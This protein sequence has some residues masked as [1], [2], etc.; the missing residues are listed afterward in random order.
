MSGLAP[1]VVELEPQEA[2]AVRGDVA[3]ADLPAFFE[4]AFHEAAAA[5]A[6]SDVE[7]VGPPFGFYPEMPTENVAVEAGFPVSEPA[8]T[9]GS[10]HRLVLP[11]GRVV[12]AVHIGT[13]DTMESTYRE[14]Q[15][16]MAE[17][18]L[19]PAVGMWEC[20]LSDPQVEPD[21]ATWRTLIVW[22]IA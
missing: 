13:Y 2:I 17:R 16:W 10:A 7:I 21:P 4:R 5:A 3:V 18:G 8:A 11:G 15:S 20:Y 9:H 22:P 1:E 14:L 12:R 6:A 19:L